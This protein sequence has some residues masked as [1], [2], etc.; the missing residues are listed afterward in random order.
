M[1]KHVLRKKFRHTLVWICGDPLFKRQFHKQITADVAAGLIVSP[2]IIPLYGSG[3]HPV[4]RET[5]VKQVIF[6]KNAIDLAGA[7]IYNHQGC[8][9][10]IV[11]GYPEETVDELIVADLCYT[12]DLYQDVHGVPTLVRMGWQMNQKS[13]KLDFEN[14]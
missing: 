6:A 4:N 8:G 1:N 7:A 5:C 11:Y 3:S 10:S 12:R 2:H 13:L 14:L 9:W